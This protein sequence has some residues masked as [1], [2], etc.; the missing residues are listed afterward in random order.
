MVSRR[1]VEAA[2]KAFRDGH[3]HYCPAPGLP[4]VREACAADLSH[5]CVLPIDPERVLLAPGAKPFSSS[6]SSP[7]ASQATR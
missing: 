2:A 6:A 5:R 1:N 4:V 3:T 7:P